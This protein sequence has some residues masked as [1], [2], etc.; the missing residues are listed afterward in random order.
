M[1]SRFFV[2]NT[3]SKDHAVFLTKSQ[4]I[5]DT[6]EILETIFED[7]LK[8]LEEIND[9]TDYS[10]KKQIFIDL[11]YNASFFCRAQHFDQEKTSCVIELMY[12]VFINCTQK[13]LRFEKGFEVAKEFLLRHALFRPPHSIKIFNLDEIKL[14]TDFMLDY[15]FKNYQMYMKAFTPLVDYEIGTFVMYKS[16]FPQTLSL[17]EGELG[18]KDDFNALDNYN[19]DKEVKLTEEQIEAIKRGDSIFNIPEA[20]RLELMKKYLEKEKQDKVD[21]LMKKE[22][23]KLNTQFL[24]KIQEQD[25]AFN[26][27]INLLKPKK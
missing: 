9:T 8:E 11:M 25:D 14:V 6:K 19:K 24:K 21:R 10:F 4:T 12:R 3:V 15:F 2:F 20:K 13:I 26:E 27:R 18:N 17:V 5:S 22:L 7:Y 23:E 16:R 1:A